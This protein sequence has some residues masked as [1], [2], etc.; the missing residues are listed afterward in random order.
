MSD[1]YFREPNQVKWI[2]SRPGHNGVQVYYDH[3]TSVIGELLL[4]PASVTLR[5]YLTY[6]D[7]TLNEA[8]A[9][10]A[11]LRVY[12]GLDVLQ[13]SFASIRNG[14]NAGTGAKVGCFNPPFELPV[15][16]YIVTY[17]SAIVT[18]EASI[19]GWEE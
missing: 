2:G 14:V 3:N 19:L 11:Q 7:V 10:W 8:V 6:Y 9:S 13:W 4:V 17:L 16:W 12:N 5:R 18:F 1:M 15:G